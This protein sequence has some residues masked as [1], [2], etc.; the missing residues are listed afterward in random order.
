MKKINSFFTSI[1]LF[2]ITIMPAYSLEAIYKLYNTDKTIVQN[3]TTNVLRNK[4]YSISN[5]DPITAKKDTTY[6]DILLTKEGNNVYYY[7]NSTNSSKSINRQ[8]IKNFKYDEITDNNYFKVFRN[9]L[10]NA[11]NG[12]KKVYTFEEE[13]TS[14]TPVFQNRQTVKNPDVMTGFAGKAGKGTTLQLY[15]QTPINT[16]TA[17]VGDEV[18][19]VLTENWMVNGYVAAEKGSILNGRITKAKSAE[20]GVRSARVT[21]VFDTLTAPNGKTYNISTK[22][23]DFVVDGDG[24]AIKA[25]K[26]AAKQAA[27]GALSGVA[28]GALSMALGSDSSALWKGAVIGAGAG[29]VTGAISGA[30]E[31]GVD[32]EIPAYTE[33]EAELSKDVDVILNY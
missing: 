8:V 29:A 19:G 21:F 31:R 12:T 33:I 4:G 16:A 15:I 25:T 24:K 14:S 10:T 20:A 6:V 22:D 3:T 7:Y 9:Q 1:L 27:I 32:V 13:K 26:T 17:S 5:T 18:T 23:I 28:I 11:K 2:S 30:F